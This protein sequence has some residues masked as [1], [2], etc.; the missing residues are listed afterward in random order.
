MAIIIYKKIKI[1]YTYLKLS[2]G[3]FIIPQRLERQLTIY[4]KKNNYREFRFPN[5]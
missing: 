5:L 4:E 2:K 1:S 3:T